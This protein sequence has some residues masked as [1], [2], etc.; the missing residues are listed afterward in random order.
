MTELIKQ[1][2]S[3]EPKS[4][5]LFTSPSHVAVDHLLS[6]LSD[7]L[8]NRIIVRIGDSEKISTSSE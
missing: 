8:F 1:I 2:Y 4:K 5:I 3:K 6:N 7:D